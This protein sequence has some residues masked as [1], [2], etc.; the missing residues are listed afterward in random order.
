M[1]IKELTIVFCI[2]AVVILSIVSVAAWR[3]CTGRDKGQNEKIR[4]H[5]DVVAVID[6]KNDT[7]EVIHDD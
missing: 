2:I 7:T 3:V 4:T 5:E 6:R 1:F